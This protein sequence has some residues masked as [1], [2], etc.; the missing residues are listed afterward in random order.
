MSFNQRGIEQS[1][2][3]GRYVWVTFGIDKRRQ[4]WGQLLAQEVLVGWQQ[5]ALVDTIEQPLGL[6]VIPGDVLCA[7]AGSVH[8]LMC[9]GLIVLIVCGAR[10]DGRI[11]GDLTTK[12]ANNY[13]QRFAWH[14]AVDEELQ[15][16]EK[17]TQTSNFLCILFHFNNALGISILFQQFH[18]N[19]GLLF[20]FLDFVSA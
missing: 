1:L 3:L 14:F 8:N 2:L 5:L 11:P 20:I 16:L 12:G 15:T 7:Q 4:M 19:V 10:K 6:N 13:Y 9:N 17:S 18:I